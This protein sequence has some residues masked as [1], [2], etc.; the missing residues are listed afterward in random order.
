MAPNA[1]PLVTCVVLN[2]NRREDTL[3]C[4]ASIEASTYRPVASIVLDCHSTDGSVEAVN[5]RF[6][7]AHV[8]E[9]AE[10]RG[11]AG[12][13]NVGIRAALHMGAAWV[14]VLNEDTILAPDCI[15]QLIG[16]GQSRPGIGIVGPLVYHADEPTVIQTAGGRLNSRWEGWHLGANEPDEGQYSDV[17][18]VEWISGCGILVRREA[19]EAV[20]VLDERFFIYWEETEWCVRARLA[21]W[22]ILN[23]PSA[24]LW[25]KG[26]QRD[27]RPKPT[28]TYYLTRN[29]LLMLSTHH[30][31]WSAWV[32]AWAQLLR[33][34][35]SWSVRPKWRAQ[36]AHRDAMARGIADFVRGRLGPM[37]PRPAAAAH[38]HPSAQA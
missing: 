18:P 6:P 25:H 27:Y 22:D 17:R 31:P 38:S 32:T 24:R 5:A 26:V 37:P 1:Q 12:N 13:N 10:N 14:F 30:A 20:G 2:S 21:G 23:A 34:L 8:I 15:E 35:V 9:L 28:V 11:Y 16:V 29:R 3:Q 4:L 33:T 7:D 36:H 19:I